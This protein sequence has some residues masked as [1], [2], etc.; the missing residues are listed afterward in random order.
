MFK[1]S[2]LK[3]TTSFLA[4][5]IISAA[6]VLP[7]GAASAH[8]RYNPNA[9]YG[10]GHHLNK[11][12]HRQFHNRYGRGH[13][14]TKNYRAQYNQRHQ[15]HTQVKRR[16]KKGELIAAGIIGLAVGA[17]I[18]SESSKHKYRSN[19]PTYY[20]QPP[21]QNVPRGYYYDPSGYNGGGYT[22]GGR[23]IPLDDYNDVNRGGPEV[24][25]FNEPRTLEPWTAG[26]RQ[27]CQNRYRS[28]NPSTGT[29]RG[30]DGLDHFCVPK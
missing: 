10:Q 23:A 1:N 11:H 8:D 26:W 21:Q 29:F 13:N 20:Q 14:G 22:N 24:I 3:K 6:V 7:V 16:N 30:Y 12:K 28:F 5:S 4:A 19:Q 2:A 27:W 18:A 25:T 17:I 15:Q 9:H